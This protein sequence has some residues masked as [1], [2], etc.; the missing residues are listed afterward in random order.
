MQENK[1]I[2][3]DYSKVENWVINSNADLNKSFDL[4]FFCGTSVLEASQDNGV[5]NATE[6]MRKNGYTNYIICG[7]QLSENARIFCPVQR[8]MALK[9]ALEYKSHANLLEDIISKEPYVDLKAALDYYFEHYNKGAERPFVLAGHSQG[10]AS[11]Q[12]C[13]KHYFLLTDKSDYLKSMI[14]AYALGYGVSKKHFEAMPNKEGR[15]HFVEGPSD[16]NCLISWNI[17]GVGEKGSS[18]LLADEGDET[19]VINPLNWKKDNTYAGIEENLGALIPK[20]NADGSTKYSLSILEEDL[21]DAQIDLKRGSVL[22]STH[23]DYINFGIGENEIWG[24]KS[25]HSYDG[26]GYYNNIKVNLRERVRNYLEYKEK[27]KK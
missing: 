18:F 4:I 8:Q 11:L 22:C 17:E 12:A 2:P 24:G 6:E 7:S 25:L 16:F 19:L 10:A 5:G 13:I 9:Y 26:R 20:K 14:A 15:I 23:K 21:C 3:L 27:S 1:I